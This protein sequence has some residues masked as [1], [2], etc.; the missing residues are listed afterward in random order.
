MKPAAGRLRDLLRGAIGTNPGLP[1]SLARIDV[2]DARNMLLV[3]QKRLDRRSTPVQHTHKGL[4]GKVLRERFDPAVG[5]PT[6]VRNV[7]PL[8][9]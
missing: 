3:E 9:P 4:R 5:V 2:S 6:D 8:R 1:Q 7:L